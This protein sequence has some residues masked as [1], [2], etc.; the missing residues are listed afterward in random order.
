MMHRRPGSIGCRST[1][2]R[3]WKNQSMPGH[4]GCTRVTVQN[5]RVLQV[6][7]EDQVLVIRGNV[8]GAPAATW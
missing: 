1:P 6:R 7:E 3:V 4:M 5:L 2:G 8:P